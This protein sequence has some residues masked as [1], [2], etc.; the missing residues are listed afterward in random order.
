MAE[1]K[2][3]PVELPEGVLWRRAETQIVTRLGVGPGDRVVI[4]AP[5]RRD[6]APVFAKRF[7]RVDFLQVGDPG[8]P[9]GWTGEHGADAVHRVRADPFRPPFPVEGVE[10][11]IVLFAFPLLEPADHRRLVSVW[12]PRLY[13]FGKWFSLLAL[14]GP[15][16]PRLKQGETDLKEVGF[17]KVRSMRLALGRMGQS[18]Y[19]QTARWP[20][21]D[22]E[23]MAWGGSAAEDDDTEDDEDDE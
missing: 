16:D 1:G 12:A 17:E 23:E 19:L 20:G 10:A 7:P 11:I 3:G 6:V 4:L 9:F 8:T 18:L 21:L 15:N 14:D 13:P 2:A 5:P 22:E